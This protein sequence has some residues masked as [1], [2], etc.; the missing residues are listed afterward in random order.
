MAER[1]GTGTISLW[2]NG[3]PIGL[4]SR[5]DTGELKA[6]VRVADAQLQARYDEVKEGFTMW[7]PLTCEARWLPVLARQRGWVL[8]GNLAVPLQRKIVAALVGLYRQKGTAQGIINAVR[9][10][11]G[12]E[13]RLGG[14][15]A[16][17]WRL[18][19]S[20]L[21]G[22]Q[23]AYTAAGG[24][25]LVDYAT[26]DA[27]WTCVPH[28]SAVRVWRNDVELAETAFLPVDRTTIALLTQGTRY[29]AAPGETRVFLDF[30]YNPLRNAL[31]VSRN[32][33]RVDQPGVWHEFSAGP[34]TGIDFVSPLTAGDVIVVH[35]LEG[36]TALT[37]G[38]VIRAET[39]DGL[40]TRL[41]APNGSGRGFNLRLSL[42]RVLSEEEYLAL[43]EVIDMMR[44][45]HLA[46]S[47]QFSERHRGYW[48]LGTSPLGR[49]ARV[50]PTHA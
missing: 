33:R 41:A 37:A 38:D 40:V 18:G 27:A 4:R 11:L 25:T 8:D 6:L 49:G 19:R 32:G 16:G 48:T 9:L 14:F 1:H 50:A 17:G 2:D 34:Y 36:R 3:L 22:H 15:W 29:V 39:D 47:I 42:P 21:G 46:V 24:E 28:V 5:D 35:N 23:V 31:V 45:A 43:H 30:V 10:F 20:H 7:D 13:A 12:E 44:P 26:T